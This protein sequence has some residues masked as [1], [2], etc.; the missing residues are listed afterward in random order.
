MVII[1]VVELNTNS[2]LPHP[3]EL[4]SCIHEQSSALTL[5]ANWRRKEIYRISH[6]S[7]QCD[8]ILPF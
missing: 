8:G 3:A 2:S 7:S 1:L 5:S 4:C 6:G